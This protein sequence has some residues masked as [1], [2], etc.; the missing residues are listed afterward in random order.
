MNGIDKKRI[1]NFEILE[2]I[3]SYIYCLVCNKV[4]FEPMMC[5]YCENNT[6]KGC[7]GSDKKCFKC[8]NEA[9][10]YFPQILKQFY[11]NLKIKCKNYCCAELLYEELEFHESMC[12]GSSITDNISF[13][14]INL[15]NTENPNNTSDIYSIIEGVSNLEC[16]NF[17]EEVSIPLDLNVDEKKVEQKEIA[18]NNILVL[19]TNINQRVEKLENTVN[20][21]QEETKEL[22]LI[23]SSLINTKIKMPYT[24]TS[25][26]DA[27]K[28]T[29]YE[30]CDLCSNIVSKHT[31][32]KC[33]NCN[34]FS[35]RFCLITCGTCNSAD[36]CNLCSKCLIC[37]LPSQCTN[38]KANCSQC[39]KNEKAFCTGCTKNCEL[40]KNDF[41]KRCCSFKC[42]DC[43]LSICIK[44][45]WNCRG[46]L[47][48][49]C[50][51]TNLFLCTFCGVNNCIDCVKSCQACTEKI[52]K[53]CIEECS[54]CKNLICQKCYVLNKTTLQ[55]KVICRN[56]LSK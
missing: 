38:C 33:V 50:K 22:K 46:C 1:I 14:N 36:T 43:N 8:K 44:C 30:K 49:F 31:K 21:L 9:F 37:K 25:L 16:N 17:I 24:N 15:T 40:C 13:E 32:V 27:K 11:K 2:L 55:K 51:L 10:I 3:E 52:C 56:C 7:L 39:I 4:C 48:N 23:I 29:P 42:S 19:D 53:Y 18:C 26:P 54:S 45:S 20:T 41:C 5:S 6:C 28:N 12:K 47:K 35:C 34:K